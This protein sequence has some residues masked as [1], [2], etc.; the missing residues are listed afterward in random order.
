MC[1]FFWLKNIFISSLVENETV[2]Y[3]K[4][5]KYYNKIKRELPGRN[6]TGGL[7]NKEGKH[8]N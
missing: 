5:L 2:L 1:G 4:T 7:I 6:N 8:L 3:T